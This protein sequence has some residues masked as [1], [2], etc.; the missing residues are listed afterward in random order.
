MMV[1]S[2]RLFQWSCVLNIPY[3]Q[4]MTDMVAKGWCPFTVEILLDNVSM[5]GYTLHLHMSQYE[6]VVQGHKK[7]T[8]KSCVINKIDTTNYVP[9]HV[10]G[11]CNYNRYKPSLE[12]VIGSLSVGKILIVQC[13]SPHEEL[14]SNNSSNTPYVVISHVWTHGLGNTTE[15][16]SPFSM[17]NQMTC[18]IDQVVDTEWG[19]LD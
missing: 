18:N 17:P 2:C 5:L 19:I 6:T 4:H 8:T 14:L 11:N 9:K 10:I 7:C 1:M 16:K 12:N 13:P 3:I 15:E